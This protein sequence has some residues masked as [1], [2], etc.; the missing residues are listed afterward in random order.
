M[1]NMGSGMHSQ[2]AHVGVPTAIAGH[3]RYPSDHSHARC[4]STDAARPTRCYQTLGT[5]E[6]RLFVLSD[7]YEHDGCRPHQP[8][9][10]GVQPIDKLVDDLVDVWPRVAC[11]NRHLQRPHVL[12]LRDE[13]RSTA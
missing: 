9:L 7:S 12:L 2:H 11:M 10:G 1:L 3:R 5:Q 6:E 13:A 4:C 8:V